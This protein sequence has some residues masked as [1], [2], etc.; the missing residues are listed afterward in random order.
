MG[1][2][3]HVG[4]C[5]ALLPTLG[6]SPQLILT[7]PPYDNLRNYGGYE[8]DFDN[9]AD[10]LIPVIPEGGI[11]VWVVA[12]ASIKG[13]ETG[14]SFRQAL[15]FMER[16]LRLHDT[17][18]Y[19]KAGLRSWAKNR[20]LQC[21]EYM[22]VFSKGAPKAAN[23]IEDR[24]NKTAGTV[25]R[26]PLAM[27]RA[28]DEIMKHTGPRIAT[29]EFGKRSNIWRIPAGHNQSAPDY[30]LAHDHPAIF[31]LNLARDHIATWTDPGDLVLDPMA[32]SGT[33][34]KAAKDLGRDFLGIEIHG[35]YA[36]IART[37]LGYPDG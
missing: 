6:I 20:Y 10:A 18:I 8:F 33:T 15:G 13:S 5:A 28:S 16:G 35:P 26:R 9:V 37:R 12:D 31:P 11:L 32:G 2:A 1:G 23:M 4:D 27:G 29:K 30:P 3:V 22:F 34:L 24:P 17:M 14:T 19:E 7:S 36:D 21:F 25:G